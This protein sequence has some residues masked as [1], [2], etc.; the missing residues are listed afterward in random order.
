[1]VIFV[2]LE[3]D[4]EKKFRIAVAKKFGGE[5]GAIEKAVNEAIKLWLEKNPD[6]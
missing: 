2:R 1:M 6:C 5:K 4:L 3:P